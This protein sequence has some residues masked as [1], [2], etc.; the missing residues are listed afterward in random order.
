MKKYTVKEITTAW[1]KFTSP[2]Y[3]VDMNRIDIVDLTK[4]GHI[5]EYGSSVQRL[6]IDYSQWIPYLLSEIW[7]SK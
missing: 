3:L 4:P 5:I 6:E 2:R 1:T 7:K